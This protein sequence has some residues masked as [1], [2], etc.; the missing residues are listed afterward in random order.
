MSIQTPSRQYTS[1]TRKAAAEATRRAV[2]SAAR[3]V[4]TKAGYA[5]STIEAVANAASVSVPTVYAIFG[6]KAGL[7]SALVADAGSDQD[8]RAFA[9]A[10]LAET[11]PTRR[12]AAAAR[13]VRT[14]MQREQSI[15]G[16]LREAGSGSAELDAARRQVHQ[17]QRTALARV[18]KPLAD[19]RGLRAGQ[20]ASEASA[21][22]AALASPECYAYFVEE[23]GWSAARWER[24]LADAA[25]RLLLA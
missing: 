1:P 10:A 4:F 17:Q 12:L 2:L 15:L 14:I 3:K 20:T 5:A 11:V 9:G 13:V 25:N 21:T 23:L 19:A 8:I 16:V 22:F 6:S 24:W 7:L 18:V